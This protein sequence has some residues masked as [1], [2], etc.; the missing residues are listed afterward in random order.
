MK[1]LFVGGTGTISSACAQLAVERGIDLYLLNRGLTSERPIPAGATVLTGD[2]RDPAAARVAIDGMTF[3]VVVEW[4]AYKPEHVETDIALFRGRAGQYFFISTASAYH[5]PV[6]SLPITESTPL[7]NPFWRYSRD[8]I[9]CEERLLRA[10]R[11]EGFPV[12]IVRPSHTYDQTRLPFR[13]RWTI[14]DRMRKGL[15]VVVH[16]DGTS[17]WVPRITRT[18][19]KASW[20]SSA[21]HR[22]LVKPTTSLP[23]RSS[24]GTKSSALSRARQ[25]QVSHNSCIYR[26]N[27]STH[28]THNGA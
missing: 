17:L 12:A 20:D 22:L 27:S 14:V 9:A 18:S 26:L 8:K 21:G 2:I 4:V 3:D 23:T 28:S 5:K 15:P 19:P 6:Q 1:V 11:D 13:G 24:R 25:G 16:G 10:Y 7:H